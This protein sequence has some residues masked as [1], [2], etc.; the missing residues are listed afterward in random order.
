MTQ[1]TDST[2]LRDFYG[3][4]APLAPR[5]VISRLD[6]CCRTFIALSPF[7]VLATSDGAGNTDASP[8]GDGPGFVIVPDDT[9]GMTPEEFQ[10]SVKEWLASAKHPRFDRR[11][12]DL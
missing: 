3:P 2:T 12:E 9:A 4:I 7:A 5:K 8:R 6:H 10:Q 1:I 11:Y